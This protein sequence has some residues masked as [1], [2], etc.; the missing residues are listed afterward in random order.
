[1]KRTK[2]FTAGIVGFIA[3]IGA[4]LGRF[5]MKNNKK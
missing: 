2:L 1:M 4:V 5:L 3:V